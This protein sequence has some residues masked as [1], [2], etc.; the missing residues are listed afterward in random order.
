MASLGVAKKKIFTLTN[1]L[2]LQICKVSRYY[3]N[4][5]DY[6]QA[7]LGNLAISQKSGIIS[8]PEKYG[9]HLEQLLVS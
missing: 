2:Q 6:V 8:F 3:Q 1:L 5:I 9:F 4:E 7:Y